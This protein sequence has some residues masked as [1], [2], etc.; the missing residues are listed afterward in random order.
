MN[1]TNM[2]DLLPWVYFVQSE[3]IP[4]NELKEKKKTDFDLICV[5]T[6]CYELSIM[7]AETLD[8]YLKNCN[9]RDDKR[10]ILYMK[11][12]YLFASMLITDV[13]KNYASTVLYKEGKPMNNVM[14]MKGIPINKS[15]TNRIA[16]A[17]FQEILEYDILKAEKV[18]I[19]SILVKL[20]NFQD[21]IRESLLKGESTF[22]KPVR[23]NKEVEAYD[24]PLKIG[25]I[26]GAMIW[27][28]LYPEKEI[29][30]PDSFFLVKTNCIKP[31]DL[32]KIDDE[33]MR[34]KIDELIF[35]N[36]EDRIKS[37]GFYLLALPQGEAIPKW[38]INC[39]DI[40]RII[41][42]TMKSFMSI[43]RAL[44]VSNIFQNAQSEQF[45][46]FISL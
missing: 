13:K 17:R 19:I 10:E 1:I 22:L 6:L 40:D 35:K 18:D 8:T 39:I 26:R 38:C 7:I 34:G 42:D 9:V 12:E 30:F 14:D 45:S 31:K 15:S 21:E 5:Y 24:D 27:N 41:E 36:P 37:K 44:E 2:L 11:N 16:S 4:K 25:G 28:E 32:E 23:V 3:V 29:I 33:E 20:N 46:S 43:I